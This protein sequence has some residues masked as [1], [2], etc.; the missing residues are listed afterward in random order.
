MNRKYISSIKLA[1]LS[2]YIFAWIAIFA[3]LRFHSIIYAMCRL[4]CPPWMCFSDECIAFYQQEKHLCMWGHVRVCVCDYVFVSVWVVKYCMNMKIAPIN[5]LYFKFCET[6]ISTP[7]G[8]WISSPHLPPRILSVTP[9]LCR[10]LY[11]CFSVSVSFLCSSILSSTRPFPSS[12]L[13]FAISLTSP[14][15][16]FFFASINKFHRDQTNTHTHMR[17]AVI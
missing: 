6:L 8:I 10:S 11:F 4:N 5:R 7:G 9:A 17:T 2:V 12:S 16:I 15:S 3:I 14:I 1:S 13:S